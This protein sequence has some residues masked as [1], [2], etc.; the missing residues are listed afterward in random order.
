MPDNLAIDQKDRPIVTEFDDHSRTLCHGELPLTAR[1]E[2][3]MRRLVQDQ[4]TS[5]LIAA[6]SDLGSPLNVIN[7]IPMATNIARLTAVAADRR[8][9]F[10]IFFARKSNKCLTFVDQCVR[11]EIGVD[12]ASENEILQSLGRGVA[13]ADLICTAAVKSESL[14]DLCLA[15]GICMAL[16]NQD[17]LDLVTARARES[18]ETANIAL[19]IGGFQHDGQKL[20][21]RFGWDVDRDRAIVET[22]SALPVRV[23]GIHFH[24]DGYDGGQRVT[25]ILEA[26][27]WVER[28]RG[29]GHQPKF[30][31]MG[32]GFPMN[33]LARESEWNAFWQEH[34]KAML[35]QRDSITY[36]N[37]ALG[38]V[39]DEGRLLGK[40]NSYPY[41]QSPVREPWLE[42]I[43]DSV[44]SGK[45]IAQLLT[46][47][48]VQLRCEP[49][50]SLLDGCGMTIAQVEFRKPHADGDWLIGLSMNRTQCRTSSDDFLV[51]PLLV[52]ASTPRP[53]AMAGYLVGAYCTE[54]EL[55]SLRRLR[56][57]EGVCRG[58]LVAFPNTAGYLMH[59]LESRSHQF[60]LAK[61]VV[62]HDGTLQ[63]LDP[64]DRPGG[65]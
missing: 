58:D 3:W 38:Q 41:Y 1:C 2:P 21:T 19:R 35:G 56:F 63:Q 48:K 60:P 29:Q 53:A 34:R 54:S 8:L 15:H 26:L 23:V 31:D 65:S 20:P 55:L 59:F 36:R 57:P 45:T 7:P 47:S 62:Y 52:A 33:Y 6:V 14:V 61:N 40:P 10:R 12:T 13:P 50:R 37:H 39:V 18:G 64:I 44:D 25:A 27:R 43:L 16:D 11:S 49:G 46:Q 17:E 22:L 4:R 51:D 24:L 30:I 32:G 28:L 9:D 42:S 5:P